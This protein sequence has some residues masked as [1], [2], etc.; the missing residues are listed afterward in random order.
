MATESK[1]TKEQLLEGFGASGYPDTETFRWLYAR[2]RWELLNVDLVELPQRINGGARA[3]VYAQV[4]DYL[5]AHPETSDD[6][7]LSLLDAQSQLAAEVRCLL[8]NGG[9]GPNLGILKRCDATLRQIAGLPP[10]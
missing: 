1:F 2:R 5:K 10:K 6:A 7:L 8:D 9:A 4:M 3:S